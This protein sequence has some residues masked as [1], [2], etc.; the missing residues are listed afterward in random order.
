M[1]APIAVDAHFIEVD[2]PILALTSMALVVLA[3]MKARIGR[4]SGLCL[5]A[6]YIGYTY[7][8]F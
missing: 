1:V 4:G 8:L 3:L 2:L 5:L 6:G 7:Y